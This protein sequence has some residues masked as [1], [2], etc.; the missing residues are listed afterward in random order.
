MHITYEDVKNEIPR[1]IATRGESFVYTTHRDADGTCMYV[2]KGKPDCLIGCYL[3]DKGLPLEAFA[4]AESKSIDD[5]FDEGHFED[6]GF[7]ADY[8]AIQAMVTLQLFQDDSYSWG[9]AYAGTFDR[10]ED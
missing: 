8:D 9:E 5:V 10:F 6:Y 3:A 4:N 2:Y 7:S 1:I